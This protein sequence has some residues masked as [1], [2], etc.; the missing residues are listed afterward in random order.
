MRS[1]RAVIVLTALACAH[2][3]ASGEIGPSCGPPRHGRTALR[4]LAGQALDTAAL[5]RQHGTL[6]V[7]TWE[8]TPEHAGADVL[9]TLVSLARADSI[10]SLSRGDLPFDPHVIRDVPA[11]TYAVTLQRIGLVKWRDTA[12]VR[13][14]H[15]DT[16]QVDLE[17]DQ[18]CG[19]FDRVY[20]D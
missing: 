8:G 14:G 18:V 7:Q 6:V 16:L 11:G 15:T 4:R 1:C 19:Y 9:V 10:R 13:A 20:P 2:R 5:R 12:A 17:V 3:G